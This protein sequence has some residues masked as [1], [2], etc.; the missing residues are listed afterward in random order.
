[1]GARG[2][3]PPVSEADLHGFVDGGLDRA[4]REAVEAFLAASPADAARAESWRRQN[5]TIRAAFASGDAA[6]LPWSLPY[7]SSAKG[8][9]RGRAAL[10]SRPAAD[11]PAFSP[12][13]RE[14]W[15]VYF[16]GLAFASGVLLSA[17][18]SHLAGRGEIQGAMPP[19]A[20]D[21]NLAAA[22]TDEAFAGEAMSALL[23]FDQPSAAAPVQ[24]S[25]EQGQAQDVAA[26]I[27][28]SLPAAGLKLTAVRA[29]PGE[30][31]QMLCMFYEKQNAG[32]LAFCAEKT[33]GPSE[34]AARLSGNFPVA[35]ISWRQQGAHYAL[36]GAL[37]GPELRALAE[38]ARVQIEA[39]GPNR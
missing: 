13:W 28:P 7:A 16:V 17:G 27:L 10:G 2:S 8:V 34:M 3:E 31:G 11:V 15:F 37:P 32:H 23:A 39:F 5:E 21:P 12:S 4:R 6:S 36:A 25:K 18:A 26:P 14:R 19:S 24:S 29:A 22:T 1:M 20:G 35:R 30:Q 9:T 38:A 33:P